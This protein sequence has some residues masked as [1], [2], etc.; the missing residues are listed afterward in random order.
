MKAARSAIAIMAAVI[1]S[2][3]GTVA[4]Q[5]SGA[6]QM[7]GRHSMDGKVTSIDAKK[8]WVHVKTQEGTMIVHFPPESLQ[9]VKKGDT[10]TVSLA[11]QDH[12][13]AAG[14]EKK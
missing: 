10:I 8:G 7:T 11:L 2:S 3:A 12:G 13:P 5:S 9:G 14:K 6:G 1:L 4:A